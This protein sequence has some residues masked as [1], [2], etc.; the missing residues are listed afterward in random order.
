[1]ERGS[2]AVDREDRHALVKRL[3]EGA[4]ATGFQ[5][6]RLGLAP[7]QRPPAAA[8][9][10][11]SFADAPWLVVLGRAYRKI[12]RPD[13]PVQHVQRVSEIAEFLVATEMKLAGALRSWP[14]AG[15]GGLLAVGLKGVAGVWIPLQGSWDGASTRRWGLASCLRG[16]SG[17]SFLVRS[18]RCG[19]GFRARATHLGWPA[20]STGGTGMCRGI[21]P[22]IP[23]GGD[24]RHVGNT[25]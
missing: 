11:L 9:R 1:M 15:A 3:G 8:K 2:I 5:L 25:G 12:R 13:L 6:L 23:C 24:P 18:G 22:R 14:A 17:R 21:S 7:K 20:A 16:S 19:A 10:P 4:T